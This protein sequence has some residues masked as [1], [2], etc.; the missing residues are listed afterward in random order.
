[1][2]V[3]Y[4]SRQLSSLLQLPN[5]WIAFSGYWPE[6]GATLETGTFKELE[7]CG[8]LSRMPTYDFRALV[9]ASAGNT[10]AAFARSCSENDIPC[11]II[12]PASGVTKMQF[13]NRIEPCVKIISLTGGAV[14]SDAI[15]LADRISREDGFVC[16]GGVK[17]VGRRDGMATAM[18]NAV[19]TMGRLPDYYFQAIGSGAGAIAAHEAA[20]RLVGDL[21]FGAAVPRLMLSQNA[22]FTPIYDSWKRGG[23]DLVEIAPDHARVLTQGIL[24]KVLSN[25]RPPYS[26]A[27]GVYDVLRESQGDMFAVQNRAAAQAMRIFQKYEGIDLDPAAGVA[28]ASLIQAV[29]AGVVDSEATVLLHITGGGA[30]KRASEKKLSLASPDLELPLAE[31]ISGAA[32]EKACRLFAGRNVSAY[33]C[34]AGG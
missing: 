24:A 8:V 15:A 1:M 22:P 23:R 14:Y 7:V 4:Q 29:N 25:L 18:L 33:A 20:Q 3:T 6:K 19:E 9:V 30:R 26:I 17:N 31:V 21:S 10:G 34:R 27:G 16:E 13:A 2:P 12:I 5:L 32:V 11:L 28:L